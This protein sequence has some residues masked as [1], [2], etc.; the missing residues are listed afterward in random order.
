MS[1]G[2]DVRQSTGNIDFR[3]FIQDSSAALVTTGTCNLRLYELQS[4]GSL[5]SFDW[6]TKYFTYNTLGVEHTGM[7]HQS[8]NNNTRATGLWT[9]VLPVVTGFTTGSIYFA[10]VEHSGGSPIVQT[11]EFQW[12]EEQGDGLNAIAD[13][14]LKRDLSVISGEG[15]RSLLN[16][17]R[18]LRNK[19]SISG[20]T[21]TI[22][23]EDDSTTAWTAV[24]TSTANPSG[25]TG[26]DPN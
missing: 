4:S 22:T 1:K 23:K 2:I 25:I 8:G 15:S 20:D 5:K 7:L 6:S 14:T 17:V 11:R 19:W 12:G 26:S 10:Q 24:L 13:A 18:F 21:I 3:A 16:A 9:T